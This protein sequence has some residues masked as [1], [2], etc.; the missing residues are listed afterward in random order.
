MDSKS[1]QQALDD[2]SE[3][4]LEKI[5]SYREQGKNQ[6]PVDEEWML[7]AEFGRAFG[8]QAYKD[9]RDDLIDADEMMTL[10][11]ANRKL[12][13]HHL[14]DTAQVSFAAAISAAS[15]KPFAT[16]KKLMRTITNNLKVDEE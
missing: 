13:Y 7:L 11:Q 2:I 4:D 3:E 5:R 15:K 1:R 8:W 6:Y 10:I 14:Y 16:F 12:E 9:A